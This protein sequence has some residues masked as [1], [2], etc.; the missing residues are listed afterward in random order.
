MFAVAALLVMA[1]VPVAFP[2]ALGLKSMVSVRLWLGAR[3]AGNVT[4]VMLKAWPDTVT[5]ETSIVAVWAAPFERVR[6]MDFV[7]PTCT[8]PKLTVE[9]LTDKLPGEVGFVG[10]VGFD[11]EV[12]ATFVPTQPRVKRMDKINKRIE[13]QAS[14][15][16]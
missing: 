8:L 4:P 11:G 15:E 2:A 10:E 13:L 16:N 5:W 12:G 3:L 14:S 1:A 9:A 6:D 7:L